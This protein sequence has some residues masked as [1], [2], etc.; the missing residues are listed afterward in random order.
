MA[1][2]IIQRVAASACVGFLFSAVSTAVL[3]DHAWATYHWARTSNPFTLKLGNNMTT[4]SWVEHLNTTV[5][6]WNSGGTP[7]MTSVVDGTAG[8]RCKM[9]AG[10]TQVCNGKYGNNGWLGLA[11]INITGG[12]HIT[13]GSA[14][15]NDTYFGTATYNNPNEKLHVVCQEVAHTFGLGHTSEDGSSQNTCMD[16]FSNTG[17]NAGS[18]LST[19][20]NTHDFY[21]LNVIYGHLDSTSTVAQIAEE[22]AAMGHGPSAV[23]RDISDDPNSW[24]QLVRQSAN[25][26]SSTYERENADGSRNITHVFWTNEAAARCPACDHRHDR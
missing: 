5:Q 16:Y 15:M 14:K 4:T 1:R 6:D 2:T 20:P 7:L 25:G 17:S 23:G 26:R 12:T 13:Q 8:K 3:A 22:V 11:S 18:T 10:T 24:G 19:K 21:Q 9:V